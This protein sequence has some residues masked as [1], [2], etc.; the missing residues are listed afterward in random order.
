MMEEEQLH[1][2]RVFV[3]GSEVGVTSKKPTSTPEVWE[4]EERLLPFGPLPQEDYMLNMHFAVS[5]IHVCTYN[6]QSTVYHGRW[7]SRTV[8]ITSDCMPMLLRYCRMC[9]GGGTARFPVPKSNTSAK[10]LI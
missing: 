3:L 1:D 5:D 2:I 6:R 4:E 10:K 9:G 7:G 8:S